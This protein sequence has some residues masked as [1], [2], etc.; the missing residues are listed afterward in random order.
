MAKT[1]QLNIRIEAD[2]KATAEKVLH[3]LGLS[4][5]QAV[6][7]FYKQVILHQGLPFEVHIPN[8]ETI[9]TIREFEQ[10]KQDLP[11]YEQFAD[12]LKEI[13]L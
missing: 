11:R 1:E 2:I 7:M 9:A 3:E 8:D 5:S 12:Y 6:Q 10:E 13:G 4:P